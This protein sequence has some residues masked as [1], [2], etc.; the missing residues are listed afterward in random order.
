MSTAHPTLLIGSDHAGFL[1]KEYLRGQLLKC[2]TTVDV[3]CYSEDSVDY[4]QIAS[5]VASGILRQD[6][7][8]VGILLCGSGNGVCISANRFQGIRAALCW[9]VEIATL[10]RLHNN[11]N[12]LCLPARFLGQEEAWNIVQAFLETPFE[13]GRHL[14]RI[15]LIENVNSIEGP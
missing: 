12:V 13:G 10:A 5:A 15:E 6:H 4:P 14:R 3:G 8:A 7:P 9:N 11:A 1:L 2:H